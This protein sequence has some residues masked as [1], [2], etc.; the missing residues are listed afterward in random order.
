MVLSLLWFRAG[1]EKGEPEFQPP[2]K[3]QTRIFRAK[4]RQKKK[5]PLPVNDIIG[6]L[7]YDTESI[8]HNNYYLIII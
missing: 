3:K 2:N 1:M 7:E 8:H 5:S 4:G 6:N